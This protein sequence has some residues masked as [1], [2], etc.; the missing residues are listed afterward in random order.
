M[1]ILREKCQKKNPSELRLTSAPVKDN[2]ELIVMSSQ[3]DHWARNRE[4]LLLDT[5]YRQ[6]ADIPLVS[7]H[8][9]PAT[10]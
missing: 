5:S 6:E 4:Q 9:Y 7:G 10:P 8:S 2:Q 1:N 3:T